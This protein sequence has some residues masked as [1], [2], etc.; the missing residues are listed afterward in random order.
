MLAI[1]SVETP[2]DAESLLGR[3]KVAEQAIRLSKLGAE[4]EQ[5]WGRVRLMGE[6]RYGELL[7]KPEPG[8]RTDRGPVTS[9]NGS[10]SGA[11]RVEQNRARS[12]SSVPEAVFTE[13]VESAP[14]PSRAGLLRA[15]ETPTPTEREATEQQLREEVESDVKYQRARAL[16]TLADATKATATLNTQLAHVADAAIHDDLDKHRARVER[17][18]SAWQRL[19]DQLVPQPLRSV[20]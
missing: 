7:P 9:G 3:I 1:D 6:R 14:K 18:I 8:K 10:L 5:R 2:E 19:A 11:Q 15:V 12:V 4:R 20:K 13:Y 16:L 17:A